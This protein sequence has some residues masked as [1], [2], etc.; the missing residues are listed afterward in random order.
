VTGGG[1][2]VGMAFPSKITTAA[3][4]SCAMVIVAQTAKHLRRRNSGDMGS[5]YGAV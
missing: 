2:G 4:A 1:A 5:P 3:D